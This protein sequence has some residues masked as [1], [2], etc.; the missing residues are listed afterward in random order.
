MDVGDDT[1][2]AGALLCLDFGEGELVD[3]ALRGGAV[4]A[5]GVDGTT[6]ALLCLDFGEGELVDGTLRGGAIGATGVDGTTGA[7]VPGAVG[8][9]LG[10]SVVDVGSMTGAATGAVV[11][12]EGI[13]ASVTC[14]VA[15]AAVGAG[16]V[17]TTGVGGNIDIWKLYSSES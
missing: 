6:G 9:A 14:G 17:G 4:G 10:E 8:D 16:T 11:S 5:T 12:V 7:C 2:D 1:G 15:G 3:G 13:G